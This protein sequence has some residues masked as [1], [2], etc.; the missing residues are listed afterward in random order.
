[1]SDATRSL[2]ARISAIADTPTGIRAEAITVT[3]REAAARIWE[4]EESVSSLQGAVI[5]RVDMF[6]AKVFEVRDHERCE[7][8]AL[9]ALCLA[10]LNRCGQQSE[11]LMALAERRTS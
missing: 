7:L 2:L 5:K 9:R 1:M 6:A 11:I 3:C 10:L 4:L 8:A